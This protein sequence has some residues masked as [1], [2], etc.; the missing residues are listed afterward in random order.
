MLTE[1]SIKAL[2]P[3]ENGHKILYD[4]LIPG[5]GCRITKNGV[6]SYIL[7]H[8]RQRRRITIG[9]VGLVS[10]QNARGEARR[11]LAGV[12]LGK[13]LPTSTSWRLASEEYLAQI[14]NK[15]RANTHANYTQFLSRFKFGET[16]LSDI[17]TR[18]IERVLDKLSDRPT[19][20]YCCFRILVQFMKWAYRRRYLDHNPTDRIDPP[21]RYKNRERILT[22]EEL[23]KV[24]RACGDDTYG[25]IV[26][27]LILTGQ[28]RGEIAQLTPEMVQGDV[29]HF[30]E[31]LTKNSRPH[32][33][34]LT[35][36]ARALLLPLPTSSVGP[37][38]VVSGSLLQRSF[39][40]WS[41]AKTDLDNR[42]G[43]PNWTLH[44]ARRTFASGLQRLGVRL[45]VIEALLNHVSG[46]KAG[47]VGIYQRYNFEPEKR[48]AME[49]WNN[50][51]QKLLQL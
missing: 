50:H 9:R 33:C 34:P 23:V 43:V 13:T 44:D 2:K 40:G 20:R 41:K 29:L 46:T 7:T 16:K 47:V 39:C 6:K 51:I 49:L 48:A 28:R 8:G 30:P 31:W 25:R 1:L 26:K 22:D 3:R 19:T 37:I 21:E 42:S 5:F 36:M 45:E 27:L 14:K 24:W 17:T 12:T 18:D 11:I 35:P 4:T 38:F 10:L 32:Q 15:R